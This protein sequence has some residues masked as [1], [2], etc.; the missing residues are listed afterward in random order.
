VSRL[1]FMQNKPNFMDT[2]I[3]VNSVMTKHYQQKTLLSYPAKQTQSKPI[4]PNLKR[5]N[6]L[7]SGFSLGILR[8]IGY[9]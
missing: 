6:R 1:P 7:L 5:K 3:F 2:H 8:R 4:K 9:T